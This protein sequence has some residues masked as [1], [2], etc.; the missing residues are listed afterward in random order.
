MTISQYVMCIVLF[1]CIYT[2]VDRICRCIEHCSNSKH[3]SKMQI[4]MANEKKEKKDVCE[5]V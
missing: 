1:I 3:Y 4:G 5:E 2:L